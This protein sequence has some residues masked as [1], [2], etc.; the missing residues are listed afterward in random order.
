M[1]DGGFDCVLGNPPWDIVQLDP[2]EFLNKMPGNI[3]N[4]KGWRKSK[5]LIP[6][7]AGPLAVGR[8][9]TG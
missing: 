9:S 4:Q 6:L 7:R 5:K 1:E 2:K 3:C 8:V